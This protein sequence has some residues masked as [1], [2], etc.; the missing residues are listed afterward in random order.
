MTEFF[1][2][3]GP[4]F[5][6]IFSWRLW[7]AIKLEIF[8]PTDSA[9]EEAALVTMQALV[10]TI[11][12]HDAQDEDA[13]RQML[14]RSASTSCTSRRRVY[15][16]GTRQSRDTPSP[17]PSRTSSSCSR[18]QRRAERASVL[19]L[20]SDLIR[21]A[22]ARDL[23]KAQSTL[24]APE[25]DSPAEPP[26]APFKRRGPRRAHLGRRHPRDHPRRHR[27]PD[28][29][30]LDPAPLQLPTSPRF[31]FGRSCSDVVFLFPLPNPL[32][33]VGSVWVWPMNEGHSRQPRHR[34]VEILSRSKRGVVG[35]RT[36]P[37][38]RR[39]RRAQRTL[40][41]ASSIQDARGGADT[42]PRR[43]RVPFTFLLLRRLRRGPRATRSIP[44]RAL[45][46]KRNCA[47]VKVHAVLLAFVPARLSEWI[48]F[49]WA[50]KFATSI[51]PHQM[52]NPALQRATSSPSH[53]SSRRS[54][55]RHTLEIKQF[56]PLLRTLQL[57]DS[58]I[59][60]DAIE[61]LLAAPATGSHEGV[62]A[63]HAPALVRT[64]LG[65][66]K[67]SSGLTSTRI[68]VASLRYLGTLPGVVTYAVLHPCKP[69]VLRE[70]GDALDDPKHGVRREVVG[71]R[72]ARSGNLNEILDVQGAVHD[73]VRASKA[74][75]V[76]QMSS[77]FEIF[78]GVAARSVSQI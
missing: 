26:L 1:P 41:P 5:L 63:E 72:E 29:P 33:V 25:S 65:Y 4:A 34:K 22:T 3:H 21:V 32:G 53:H 7:I 75:E 48:Q 13:S 9:T 77:V 18:T 40:R 12:A 67:T 47:V 43:H 2:V 68:R 55:T 19:L 78:T 14:A 76:S 54:P 10:A 50:Q 44:A 46:T 31:D 27:T 61:A 15:H 60:A 71:A 39:A 73:N 24:D 23:V 74:S 28:W 38:R 56:M 69:E 42:P 57:P 66:T 30:R 45:L 17:T 6:C 20:L 52:N 36:P 59:R 64:L 16:Q 70:L 11:H 58:Q 37:V 35:N 51:L 8:W 62:L 49:I